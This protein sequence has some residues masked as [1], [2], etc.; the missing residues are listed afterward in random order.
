MME[1][2]GSYIL[3]QLEARPRGLDG[4][5][6]RFTGPHVWQGF[7]N[8]VPFVLSRRREACKACQTVIDGGP[9]LLPNKIEAIYGIG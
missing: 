1:E 7:Q 8:D 2:M 6:A 5:Q 4:M 3:V 9:V